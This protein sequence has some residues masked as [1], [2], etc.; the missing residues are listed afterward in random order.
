MGATAPSLCTYAPT[1]FPEVGS[2]CCRVSGR[3]LYG[4]P[5]R[6]FVDHDAFLS[7]RLSAREVPGVCRQLDDRPS[8][9]FGG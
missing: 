3:Q 9:E 4:K 8:A 6:L 2:I 7:K 1:S 5:R